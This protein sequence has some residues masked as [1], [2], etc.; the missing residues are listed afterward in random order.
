MAY[1]DYNYTTDDSFH[2][3]AKEFGTT[4]SEIMKLNNISPPYV[5]KVGNL[6]PQTLKT[7]NGSLKVP[8]IATGND[9]FESFNEISSSTVGLSY[10]TYEE[11]IKATKNVVANSRQSSSV[12][13]FGVTIPGRHMPD[14]YI[15][16]N[17]TTMMFPCYP[18]SVSDSNSANYYAQSILGRS[19]PI[20]IYQNSGPRSV[21]VAFKMHNEMVHNDDSY[22]ADYDY[23]PRLVR[24]IESACYPNYGS[25]VSAVRATLVV[26]KTI[27]ISGIIQN[28][29]TTWGG[30][31]IDNKYQVVDINFSVTECTG[32]PKSNGQI[33]SMGGYR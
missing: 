32:S 18:E 17:G 33:Q 30:T 22:I 12:S 16:V 24:L 25:A 3:I 2:D 27:K 31:I 10:R 21:S 5:R 14:C 8:C 1:T 26:G 7:L 9:S 11:F 6:S 15:C 13:T 20:Q 28:V 4:V 19:E 23:V 29:S